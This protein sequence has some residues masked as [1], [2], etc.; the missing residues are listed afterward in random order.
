MKHGY[1]KNS[2]VHAPGTYR[3]RV[4]VPVRLHAYRVRQKPLRYVCLSWVR[5]GY[6]SGTAWVRI[7]YVLGTSG[8]KSNFLEIEGYRSNI[9]KKLKK[10]EKMN[11][12]I[13]SILP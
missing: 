13:S 12:R 9:K 8:Q 7:R 2:A 6:G 10:N 5:H 3:V 4:R 1:S 11:I